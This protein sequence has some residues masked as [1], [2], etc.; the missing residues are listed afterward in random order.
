MQMWIAVCTNYKISQ[1]L[2]YDILWNKVGACTFYSWKFIKDL[3]MK[4][5]LE[6][7]YKSF[8]NT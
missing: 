4:S 1:K 3:A 8:K 7:N 5:F 6:I 2:Y